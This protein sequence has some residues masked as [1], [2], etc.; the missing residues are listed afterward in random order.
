MPA[1]AVRRPFPA[2]GTLPLVRVVSG[3]GAMM[4]AMEND[5]LLPELFSLMP[6]PDSVRE[7][8]RVFEQLP[9]VRLETEMRLFGG[10]G[11]RTIFIPAGTVLTGAETE[12]DNVCFV[13]GDITVTTDEGPVRLTGFRV[14]S[15]H[16][17]F[18]RAGY[19][20][21]DTWW[22]TAWRTDQTD[23]E[24][25]EDE[26]TA[27]ADRLQTRNPALRYASAPELEG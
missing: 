7:A 16:A 1:D 22:A 17:G 24:A 21:A 19:A 10:L 9:Q 26:M 2:A 15:A 18:K 25:A 13:C 27:E 4:P 23:I 12:L 5:D 3:R 6:D 14:I 11:V 8:E 20:H